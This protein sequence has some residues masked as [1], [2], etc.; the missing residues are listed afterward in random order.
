MIVIGRENDMPGKIYN[1]FRLLLAQKAD[2]EKRNIPLKEVQRETGIA[3][4]ALQA[5]ANN[6]V[7]RFDEPVII[8][9]CDYLGCDIKDLLV[10]EKEKLDAL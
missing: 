10:Y 4:T 7:H 1:K 8:K 2:N 6:K 3:W 9:L 5:W